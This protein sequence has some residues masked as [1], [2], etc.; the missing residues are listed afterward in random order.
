MSMVKEILLQLFIII[1][2]IFVYQ[3]IWLARFHTKEPKH[4]PYLITVFSSFSVLLCMTF[5]VT[6]D[7]G[8]QYD[9][10]SIPLLV[11]ILYGGYVPGIIT[12]LIAFVYRFYLG[13]DGFYPFVLSYLIYSALPYLL[14]NKWASFSR[15]K[16]ILISMGVGTIRQISST[17]TLILV[18][19]ILQRPVS[20]EV[21][22]LDFLLPIGV[23]H[24][25]STCFVVFLYEDITQ[26]SLLRHQIQQSEKLNI[27]SELAAS[28][29]HEVR[30]PLT[31]VK[32]FIQILDDPLDQKRHEYSKL[33]LTEINRAETIISDYL[34]FAKPQAENLEPLDLSVR[35]K[36]VTGIM[37]SYAVMQGVE[38]Q[39][40]IEKYIYVLGD[41][42][43]TK[44]ALINVIKNAIE[45]IDN[46]GTIHI[47]AYS[48]QGNIIVTI[49]DTGQGMTAEQLTQLGKPFYTL[50][51]KGTGLGLMVT[52][53]IIESMGGQIKYQS[54]YGKGTKVTIQLPEAS[55]LYKAKST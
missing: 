53:R 1:L 52:F 51:E 11:A 26:N 32:G 4:N 35:I 25:L 50:K 36:E 22:H 41:V 2:P 24:I 15:R 34:N 9:L 12:A 29:A 14:V 23:L 27:I 45:A 10:R 38:L 6:A 49:A 31:V 40:E 3:N 5:P 46:G 19:Y 28:V 37:S 54:E 47:K 21:Y 44:Q 13:G 17:S 8:I 42:S 18:S 20:P 43:Q 7:D 55:Q 30:N 33:I 48:S 16:K 39:T